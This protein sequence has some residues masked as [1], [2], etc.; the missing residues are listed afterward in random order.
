[1]TAAEQLGIMWPSHEGHTEEQGIYVYAFFAEERTVNVEDIGNAVRSV[2]PTDDIDLIVDRI[3]L[4]EGMFSGITTGF[5]IT[6][7][8][9]VNRWPDDESWNNYMRDTFVALSHFGACLSW[10]GGEDCSWSLDLFID[11]ESDTGNVY[12]GYCDEEGYLC[13]S[14]LSE[15][16][17]YLTN[18]QLSLL[19]QRV[20]RQE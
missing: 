9:R 6:I 5:V 11:T 12:S 1:M 13:N 3:D 18:E 17:K 16:M 10:A 4:E 19:G 8:I 20:P 14:R 15:E 7:I 2:W